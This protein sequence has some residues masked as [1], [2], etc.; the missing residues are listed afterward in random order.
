[1]KHFFIPDILVCIIS[2]IGLFI[3]KSAITSVFNSNTSFF[4]RI[5]DLPIII[6]LLYSIIRMPLGVSV[7]EDSIRIIRLIGYTNLNNISAIEEYCS[8]QLSGAIRTFGNGGLF[9]Y[10]GYYSS[11]KIGKFQM[12]AINTK[13]L[14]LVTLDNGKKYV[15][16][17]PKELLENKNNN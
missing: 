9:G 14:A 2:V 13:E 17:Y 16:N 12:I 3:L 15:I 4:I 10:T 7:R 11:S 1:M 5:M 6:L 8:K